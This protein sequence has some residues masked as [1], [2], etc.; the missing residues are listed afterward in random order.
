[1]NDT[2]RTVRTVHDTID[3]ANSAI[4]YALESLGR[5]IDELDAAASG[6]PTDDVR[7]DDV[8]RFELVLDALE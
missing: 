1:M 2:T 3:A 5:A 8:G 4:E 6:D 7:D